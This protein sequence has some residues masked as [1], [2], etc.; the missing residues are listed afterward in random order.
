M[1]Y[2]AT[3]VR[4]VPVR[5]AGGE[6]FGAKLGVLGVWA[7][8]VRVLRR[9]LRRCDVVH[10]RCPANIG[11]LA[12]LLLAVVREPRRRWIKYAGNWR[13]SGGDF[14]S[15]ALQRWLLARGVARAVVTVNGQ[16]PDQ[17]GHVRPF[18]NP[19]LTEEELRDG[20]IVG[21]AKRLSSP[22]RLLFVGR[23]ED[24]KGCGR[25]VDI[26]DGLSRRGIDARLDLVGD[27][28]DREALKAR[29][30]SGGL[31]GRV[32]MLGWVPRPALNDLYASAHILLFPSTSS[33]GWPKVLSEGMAYGVVPLAGA[34]SSIPQYLEAFGAGKALD[35]H[36]REAFVDA[37]AA[38]VQDPRGWERDASR[39]M[40]AAAGFT[41][42]SYLGAVRRILDLEAA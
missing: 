37:I 17:P 9:E 28:P 36:D 34:V 7:E 24:A 12:I 2:E 33:E 10:V 25:A 13:P 40:S 39:A 26:T 29:I 41:Y 14:V 23:I 5:P 27:G 1:P 31:E 21:S 19:C 20:A 11:L 8:Y 16:W 15:Y 30:A 18:L 32:R 42:S 4:F 38:Y 22:L 3:N 35:P 6:S